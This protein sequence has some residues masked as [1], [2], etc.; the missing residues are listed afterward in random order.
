MNLLAQFKLLL[1]V[2]NLLLLKFFLLF[3]P[4]AILIDLVLSSQ[5]GVSVDLHL[6]VTIDDSIAT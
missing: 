2:T 4:Y 5:N 6:K 3:V 1:P